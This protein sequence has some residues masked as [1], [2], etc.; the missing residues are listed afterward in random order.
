MRWFYAGFGLCFV[1]TALANA[2]SGWLIRRRR[3]RMFS[4]VVAALNCMGFPFATTLGVFTFVVLLRDSVVELYAA[5]ASPTPALAP[6]SE[7]V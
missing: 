5:A 4:L 3:A 2:A 1:L 6:P 7:G